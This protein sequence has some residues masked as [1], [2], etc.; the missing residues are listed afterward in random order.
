MAIQK[1][2]QSEL[3]ILSILWQ[4]G[5]LTVRDV[6]EIYVKKKS[7]VG[8][9]TVLKFMQVMHEKGMLSRDTSSRAHI[10]ETAVPVEEMQSLL[11]K[12]MLDGP[13][14]GSAKSLVLRALSSSPST[15]EELAEIRQLID[16]LANQKEK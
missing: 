1:P 10:Y 9:T 4:K 15:P 11:V 7:E 2:T 16:Q 12:E 6:H 13:F 3:D 5:P 14:L 8:Y